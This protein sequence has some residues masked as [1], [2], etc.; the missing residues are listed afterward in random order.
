MSYPLPSYWPETV[1]ADDHRH[2]PWLL[3]HTRESDGAAPPSGGQ[4][5]VAALTHLSA[6]LAFVLCSLYAVRVVADI[7]RRLTPLV[8]QPGDAA[9]DDLALLRMAWTVLAGAGP[10]LLLVVTTAVVAPVVVP[11]I[12]HRLSAVSGASYVSRHALVAAGLARVVLV[13]GGVEGIA[14]VVFRS[15]GPEAPR[16]VLIAATAPLVF[17]C[18]AA[19]GAATAATLGR[20]PWR[21]LPWALRPFTTIDVHLP[22]DA[23]EM[24]GAVRHL[25]LTAAIIDQ[26]L[27]FLLGLVVASASREPVFRAV[28]DR[29]VPEPGGPNAVLMQ[30]FLG[31]VVVLAIATAVGMVYDLLAMATA[32]A[33][34]GMLLLRVR[35]VR[36]HREPNRRPGIVF[37]FKRTFIV[38]LLALLGIALVACSG[39]IAIVVLL[40][41]LLSLADGRAAPR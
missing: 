38:R 12:V 1:T 6:P 18:G 27:T 25:R 41:L 32:G 33:T 30:L 40:A 9:A 17:W 3:A 39:A 24:W 34:P 21:R 14:L 35:F 5:I 36:S 37:A 2:V 22:S 13:L 15:F 10:D 19:V 23:P 11:L 31:I 28:Y 8:P 7:W 4:R 16:Y 26:W 20:A 29:A